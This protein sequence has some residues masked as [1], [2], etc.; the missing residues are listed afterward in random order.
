MEPKI[1]I[2]KLDKIGDR[3]DFLVRAVGPGETDYNFPLSISRTAIAIWGS[4]PNESVIF[5]ASELL[6]VSGTA[7]APPREG[8]WFDSYNSGDTLKETSSKIRNLG[9]EPFIKN[10]TASD[11]YRNLFGDSLF[12]K[13]D[14]LNNDF[15]SKFS[16]EFVTSLDCA[17]EFSQA[18]EDL[19]NSPKD[20]AN[21]LIRICILSGIIDHLNVR[22]PEEKKDTPTLIAL[23]NWLTE[24]KDPTQV[25]VILKPFLMVKYL[26]KQ[27]PIHDN[28][29][30]TDK[31]VRIEREEISQAKQFFNTSED[32]ATSWHNVL[33]KF[34]GV[35]DEIIAVLQSI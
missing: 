20:L 23:K 5:L 12:S 35:L 4:A 28:Y 32:Y 14:Q 1:S 10:R 31:G 34:S 9:I 30:I 27:Y 25:E 18:K 11:S 17:F 13:I 24:K 15:T 19:N 29:R 22:L 2:Q 21:F 3:E 26:R 7:T 16:K 8:F 6:A 33:I